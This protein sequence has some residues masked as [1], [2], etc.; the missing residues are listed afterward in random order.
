MEEVKQQG[1]IGRMI[2]ELK[3]LKDKTN[4]AAQYLM[5]HN[6]NHLLRKQYLIMILYIRILSFRIA[7]AMNQKVAE[8]LAEAAC[9][10]FRIK[11]ADKEEEKPEESK[12]PEADEF[13]K[14]VF[15]KALDNL[16]KSLQAIIDGADKDDKE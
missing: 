13:D 2:D 12:K 15:D 3:E 1:Y 10:G 8:K 9:E 6:D 14:E 4:K 11:D 7:E 5:F 16:S